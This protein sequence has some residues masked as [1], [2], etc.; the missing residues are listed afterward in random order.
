MF[1]RELFI[2]RGAERMRRVDAGDFECTRVDVRAGKRHDVG[3]HRLATHDIADRI[4]H[5]RHCRD[6]QQ[7]IAV[8]VETASLDVDHDRE[9]AAETLDQ[10][11]VESDQLHGCSI[12]APMQAIGRDQARDDQP[13]RLPPPALPRPPP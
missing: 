2:E 4:H 7:C 8:G 10:T 11:R 6:F 3:R 9:K 12:S 1:E 13:E 5:D